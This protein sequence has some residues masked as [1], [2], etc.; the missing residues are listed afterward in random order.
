MS[1]AKLLKNLKQETYCRLGV[2]KIHSV[3]V[4]AIKDIPAGVD[5]FKI[6][7]GVNKKNH[8]HVQIKKSDLRKIDKAV[9]KMIDDFISK[10]TDD[11]YYVPVMG[12]NHIDI[13]F[14]MNHSKKPNV[15]IYVA[16]NDNFMGF[17]TN[18]KIKKGTELLINYEKYQD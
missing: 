18:K 8:K 10:E 4:I 16:K 7:G 13:T 12:L 9:L 6:A 17:K 11:S 2:S 3:G 5:P 1:K 14:Y 15:T